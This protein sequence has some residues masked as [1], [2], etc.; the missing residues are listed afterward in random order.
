MSQQ[1]PGLEKL[2]ESLTRCMALTKALRDLNAALEKHPTIANT[3]LH[4]L[5]GELAGDADAV[6]WG[7]VTSYNQ[8][9][10]AYAAVFN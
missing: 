6:Q 9:S 3:D 4:K 7:I 5:I 2:S 8:F 1:R 10:K